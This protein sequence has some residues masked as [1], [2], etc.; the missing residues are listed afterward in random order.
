VEL[1]QCV[2]C[3]RKFQPNPQV[4]K[5][6]YC[7][8]PKCQQERRRHKQRAKRKKDPDYKDNQSRAQQAWS[9]RNTDYWREYRRTHPEYLERNRHLQRERSDKRKMKLI[10]KMGVSEPESPVPS[11]I[12]RL[13]PMA[14]TGIAKMD[15]WTLEIKF[16]SNT[17]DRKTVIA[18]R[19]RDG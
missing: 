3:R 13:V 16:L 8:A 1:K 18:K 6:R 11:G 10:A 14:V 12:Y 15:V 7:S 2:A 5:Q 4:P 19:G 17:Y 9:K